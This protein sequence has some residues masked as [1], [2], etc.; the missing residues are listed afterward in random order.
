MSRLLLLEPYGSDSHRAWAEGYAASSA[1]DVRLVVL[2]GERWRLRMR[3]GARLLDERARDLCTDGWLPDVVL[4]SGM[5]NIAELR[6]LLEEW[7]P[8]VRLIAYYHENQLAYPDV[9]VAGRPR[10]L[11]AEFAQITID[12]FEAAD[13]V[14][15]NSAHHLSDVAAGLDSWLPT[16]SQSP[17]EN[18]PIE[19]V[20]VG[21]D[22][23]GIDPSGRSVRRE[24]P[25]LILW[26]HRW[27]HDKNPQ[28]FFAALEQMTDLDWSLAVV[29]ANHRIDPQEFDQARRTFADRI[30]S[31][32]YQSRADY[33]KL[34]HKS[35]IVVS[36]AVHEYFGVAVV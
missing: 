7:L 10:E 20:P 26:N 4:V 36:T 25:P 6:R 15:F 18:R 17:L 34:L 11:A 24:E 13:V 35:D 31:W 30:V 12:S 27:D 8:E 29:G 33:L 21:V 14:V 1:H 28:A 2:P 19:V 22:L 16:G 5:V 23:T 32:G 3:E 9:D